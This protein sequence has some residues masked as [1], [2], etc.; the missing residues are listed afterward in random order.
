MN[1]FSPFKWFFGALS[2]ESRSLMS[3]TRFVFLI[4]MVLAW[5]KWDSGTEIT[6]YFFYFILINLG[7]LFFKSKF[8]DLINKISDA[9]I[10][11]KKPKGPE[12]G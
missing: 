8:L 3:L 11:L 2:A 10:T 9:I 6:D 12:N 4:S 7:Y 5:K 1:F